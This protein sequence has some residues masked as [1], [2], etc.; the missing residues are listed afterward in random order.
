MDKRSGIIFFGGVFASGSPLI[1]DNFQ[2]DSAGEK[3][4]G[5][6]RIH[7]PVGSEMYVVDSASTPSDPF[8]VL[9]NKSLFFS[10]LGTASPMITWS[11]AGQALEVGDVRFTL[12][13]YLDSS[14][15]SSK[16]RSLIHLGK[17]D[18]PNDHLN[19]GDEF[20]STVY[21]KND[22]FFIKGSTAGYAANG[23]STDE[24]WTIELV[25]N[26]SK[27]TWSMVVNG[28]KMKTGSGKRE[29][30]YNNTDLGGVNAVSI[31]G[32]GTESSLAGDFI[33]DVKLV[34]VSSSAPLA[35]GGLPQK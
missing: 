6:M 24:M 4:S 19:A 22:G 1:W 16:F 23:L 29:F 14:V 30:A 10:K 2:S 33:D 27:Q 31:T 12:K 35:E 5:A 7:A 25:L 18:H 9:G 34:A 13:Y 8:G 20:I 17:V 3:P 21:I 15:V 32:Y 28:K 26:A 11:T